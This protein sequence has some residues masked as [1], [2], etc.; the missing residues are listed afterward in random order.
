MPILESTSFQS[1]QNDY[2]EFVHYTYCYFDIDNVKPTKSNKS[3]NSIIRIKMKNILIFHIS[4][5]CDI[6][7][8]TQ[9]SQRDPSKSTLVGVQSCRFYLRFCV[10]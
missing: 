2:T 3:L 7:Y 5:F 1:L 6:Q 10:S 9:S 4:F 8:Q